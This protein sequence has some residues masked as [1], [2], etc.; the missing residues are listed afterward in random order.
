M[1]GSDALTAAF[2]ALPGDELSKT[3][4]TEDKNVVLEMPV[5]EVTSDIDTILNEEHE[6]IMSGQKSVDDGIRDAGDRVKNEVL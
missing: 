1:L 6:L 5:S 2:T 3:T 4:F